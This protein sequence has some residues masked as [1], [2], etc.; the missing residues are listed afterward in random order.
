MG[1]VIRPNV[2]S[3]SS[4]FDKTALQEQELTSGRFMY[5]LFSPEESGNGLCLPVLARALSVSEY[6]DIPDV[7]VKD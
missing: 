3:K 7:S 6:Y 2:K 4:H 5:Q 1:E